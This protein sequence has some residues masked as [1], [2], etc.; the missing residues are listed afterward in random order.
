[1]LLVWSAWVSHGCWCWT[2]FICHSSVKTIL[3]KYDAF[4]TVFHFCC[5]HLKHVQMICDWSVA[6]V[7]GFTFIELWSVIGHYTMLSLFSFI[8]NDLLQPAEV[9]LFLFRVDVDSWDVADDVLGN[10]TLISSLSQSG[11]R[12]NSPSRE[13]DFIW[14]I[15]KLMIITL[16][17][18]SRTEDSST[19]CIGWTNIGT[20]CIDDMN[21]VK[22]NVPVQ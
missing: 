10:W 12:N 14:K 19:T 11:G 18:K 2:L 5:R 22:S 21:I 9:L 3:T 7:I 20:P 6:I 17:F 16:L 15:S 4:S 8:R 13:S 1:M